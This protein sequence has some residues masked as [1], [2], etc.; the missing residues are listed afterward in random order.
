MK[1]SEIIEKQVNILKSNKIL[2]RQQDNDIIDD[3]NSYNRVKNKN[4][5]NIKNNHV[6]Y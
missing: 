1:K 5:I 2:I 6:Y 3:I 4:N